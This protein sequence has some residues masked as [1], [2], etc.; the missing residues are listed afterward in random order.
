MPVPRLGFFAPN[1]GI[2]RI[3]AD[4]SKIRCTDMMRIAGRTVF[5]GACNI[6]CTITG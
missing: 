1:A 4:K 2:A 5:F 3:K 6:D